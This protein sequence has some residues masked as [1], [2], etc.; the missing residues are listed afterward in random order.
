MLKKS[1]YTLIEILVSTAVFVIVAIS[2]YGS[3]TSLLTFVQN[4]RIKIAAID[5][6]NEEF[7]IIRNMPY[8]NVGLVNGVPAGTLSRFQNIVRDNTT[9]KITTTIQNIDDPFDGVVGGTPNDTSP[10]DYKLVE[11]DVDCPTCKSFNTLTFSGHVSSK[12]LEAA[13]TNGSLFIQ[14]LDANGNPVPQASVQITNTTTSPQINIQDETANNGMYQLVNTPPSVNG[15]HIVVSKPG[16]SSE[17]TYAAG[18]SNPNPSKPDLTVLLQQLTQTTLSIDKVGTVNVSTVL[19]NCT[20]VG[21]VT[22]SVAGSKI[23]GTDNSSNPIYKYTATKTTNGSGLSVLSNMEWDSYNVNLADANYD[24]AGSIS[25]LPFALAPGSTQ[26]V[27]LA[28]AP[29]NPK[30]ILFS[31]KDAGTGLPVTN[32][33]VELTGS[34]SYDTTLITSRGYLTQTDWSGGDSQSDFTDPTKFFTSDGNL[35]YTSVPRQVTLKQSFGQYSIPSGQLISS[36]FDTGSASN[37]Y[38]LVWNPAT[39]PVAVGTPNARF[40]LA[41][42]NDDAT[43]NFAGPDGTAGSYYDSSNQNISSSNNGNR[44]LRY[45]LFLD[46]STTTATPTISQ[47]SFTYTSNCVPPG[48]VLFSHLSNDSYD[49]S[50]TKSG[51][52]TSNGSITLNG[53]SPNWQNVNISLQPQ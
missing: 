44:Y 30:S 46:T 10:A 45:K 20:P 12:N 39:Q 50:I 42:N 11:I 49:Y 48:Q 19:P 18:G 17:Q 22:Y 29:K 51:Y 34:G 33:T 27:I 24:L 40:Q 31:I 26:N 36:T 35:D 2:V 6:A 23:I 37:F 25:Q 14:V 53:G 7:E 5:L 8:A 43:W 16:Y 21:N 32:A 4:A 1:G 15:Y 3:Y 13:S 9:F 41:T 52:Q 38:Q 28:V 47:T